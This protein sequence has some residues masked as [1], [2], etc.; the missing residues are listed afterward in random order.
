MPLP[1]KIGTRN[2]KHAKASQRFAIKMQAVMQKGVVILAGDPAPFFVLIKGTGSPAGMTT[3][4]YP[5]ACCSPESEAPSFQFNYFL[6]NE[7]WSPCYPSGRAAPGTE[8]TLDK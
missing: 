5:Y 7:V 3:P 2:R 8:S 4:Y 6:S 1:E